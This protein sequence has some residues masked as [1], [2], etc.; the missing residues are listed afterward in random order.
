MGAVCSKWDTL[1]QSQSVHSIPWYDGMDSEDRV[2]QVGHFSMYPSLS[3]PFHGTVGWDGQW[4][5]DVASGT[6]RYVSQSVYSV[7]WYSRMGWTVRTGCCKW[8]TL[9]CIA[10]RPFHPMVQWDGGQGVASGTYT[11]VCIL[12]RPFHFHGTEGWDG[13]WGQDVASGT[14]WCNPSLSIPSCGYS[15]EGGLFRTVFTAK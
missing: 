1:V 9:V 6:L 13:Q 5:Q 4:G 7:P 11:L 3:I 12:V 2:Y 8:D 10:V 14:L 15:S